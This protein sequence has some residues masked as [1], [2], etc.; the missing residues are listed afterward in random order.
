MWFIARFMHR[1]LAEELE[2]FGYERG[3][4]VYKEKLTHRR[5]VRT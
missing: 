3:N 1:A 4:G 5:K 2:V